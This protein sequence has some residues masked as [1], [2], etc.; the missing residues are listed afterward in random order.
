MK[1]FIIKI[2]LAPA[3]GLG[4]TLLALGW[5]LV[6]P[7]P[8]VLMPEPQTAYAAAG[9]VY[10]VTPGGSDL[11]CDQVFTNVQAAVDAA[12]G[13][14]EIYVASGV[15]TD[16]YTRPRNDIVTTGVVTQMVYISKSVTIR[17]GYTTTNWATPYPLTQPTTLDAQ[18]QGRVL[19][20][21]GDI[22]PTI[23]GLRITGGNAVGLGGNLG[24]NAGGWIVT[25]HNLKAK[26]VSQLLLDFLFP[27][28]VAAVVGA[29]SITQ[30]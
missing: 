5:L 19:Y 24:G 21:T 8:V 17:G 14:E 16:V 12:S 28:P 30:N 9:D 11:A 7:G 25:N 29:A 13:G 3:L 4:L 2:S 1:R 22:S 15:Y 23:E 20:I 26:L 6:T 18:G 27:E 10:C